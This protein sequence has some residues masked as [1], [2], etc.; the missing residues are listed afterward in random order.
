LRGESDKYKAERVVK[1]YD[2]ASLEEAFSN[3][4]S[5]YNV[6]RIQQ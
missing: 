3:F 6:E 5:G 2:P 1:K 4:N